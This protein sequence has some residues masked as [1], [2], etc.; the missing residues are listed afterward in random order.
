M[1]CEVQFSQAIEKMREHEAEL[2][3][4]KEESP[5][6]EDESDASDEKKD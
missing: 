2:R 1:L 5:P 3:R 4:A 6:A